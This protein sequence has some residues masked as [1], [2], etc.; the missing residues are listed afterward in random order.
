MSTS[1]KEHFEK[2][3]ASYQKA[4]A[5]IQ[6]LKSQKGNEEAVVDDKRLKDVLEELA[7]QN[8]VIELLK[9]EVEAKGAPAG[10][11]SFRLITQKLFTSL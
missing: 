7:Q 8:E 4:L 11:E 9:R 1:Y 2:L 10:V 3:K 5:E 6:E